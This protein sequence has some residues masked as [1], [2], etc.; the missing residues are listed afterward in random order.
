[1]G[2]EL[3]VCAAVI[4]IGLIIS[5]L[6]GS[7]NFAIIITKL[8]KKGDIRDYG[9]GNAGM[10]NVL[11]SVGKSAA[12]LTL[13]G[14]FSKGIISVIIMRLLVNS[15]VVASTGGLLDQN[16]LVA[17]YIAVYGALL[18]H[19][20]PVFYRF[21]GGKGILVSFG[22]IMMLSPPAGLVCL[23]AFIISVICTKY[24]S[25]GSIV[26]AVVFPISI[27]A[28]NLIYLQMITYE[29]LLTLPVS[30][31]IVFMHRTNIKRLLSHNESKLSFKK[32]K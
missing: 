14:D 25:F 27:A 13:V 30:A 19:V 29:V 23:L 32:Q 22:A 18:G 4:G 3:W 28:F 8:F 6:L 24:V 11:R 31:M 1:M 16:L 10:T 5:Y 15:L 20:F 26:A 2:I 17:D 12:A 9:S 7:I 21:K